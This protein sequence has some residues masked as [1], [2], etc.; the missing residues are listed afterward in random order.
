MRSWFR[1]S[2]VV[3]G[4][5]RQDPAVEFTLRIP[6]LVQPTYFTDKKKSDV[7]TE[8]LLRWLISSNPPVLQM[9]KLRPREIR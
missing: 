5:E 4:W 7:L 3:G 6:N 8:G 9:G 2:G 1:W